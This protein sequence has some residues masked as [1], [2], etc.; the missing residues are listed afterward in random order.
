MVQLKEFDSYGNSGAGCI[1]MAAQ[2]GA[3]TIILVGFDCQHSGGRSH[4]HGD[5]PHHL[6]NAGMTHQWLEN[7]ERMAQDFDTIEIIN[8]SR[9]TALTCFPRKRLESLL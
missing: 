6:G 8:A 7:Y 1:S 4:W 2:A 3:K 9:E 5:H